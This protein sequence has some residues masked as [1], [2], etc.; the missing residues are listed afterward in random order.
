MLTNIKNTSKF[1]KY[2]PLTIQNTRKN[3]IN[4]INFDINTTN[5]KLYEH[6]TLTFNDKLMNNNAI[7][8]DKNYESMGIDNK[9][10]NINNINNVIYYLKVNS[11][12]RNINIDLKISKIKVVK[13]Y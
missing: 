10:F 3:K 5:S 6:S 12:N 11:I 4:E 13:N 9:L 1:N 8:Y 7:I 2:N